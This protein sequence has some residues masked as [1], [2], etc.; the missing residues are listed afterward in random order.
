VPPWKIVQPLQ[1]RMKIDKHSRQSI[2]HASQVAL[3]SCAAHAAGV[4]FPSF[5]P[6]IDA[7]QF[8]RLLEHAEGV[9]DDSKD[10]SVLWGPRS[11]PQ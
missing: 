8:K 11:I 4:A 2:A 6:S 1:L 9:V 5:P 7:K 10:D 3:G